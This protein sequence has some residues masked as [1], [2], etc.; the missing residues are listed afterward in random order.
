MLCSA[1]ERQAA[2]G[3]AR[4][5]SSPPVYFTK[6]AR[7]VR[8]CRA[9]EARSGSPKRSTHSE[10]S[11]L[12]EQD[13]GPLVPLV[14]DAVEIFRAWGAG[15]SWGRS[16]PGPGVKAGGSGPG[17]RPASHRPAR[18]PCE[19][20]SSPWRRRGPRS[21]AA[22]LV[23]PRLLRRG[24]D[25]LPDSCPLGPLPLTLLY[26]PPLFE[27]HITAHFPATG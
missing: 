16:R 13:R 8:R 22:S 11:Q 25:P 15:V 23:S 12:L 6:W 7:W 3:S 5:G 21:W 4:S 18:R 10:R 26:V 19:P 24:Q 9:A 2:A 14:D 1:A 27:R 20:A 17:G